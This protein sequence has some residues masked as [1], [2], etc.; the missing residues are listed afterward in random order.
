MSYQVI[1]PFIQF[2]D[3]SNGKPLSAGTVY[4]GRMDSDPKN[5]PANRINVYAVQDNGSEVLLSQPIDL[6]GAGQP[7]VSGSVKQIR[8]ELYAGEQSYAIQIFNRRGAQKGYCSRV[9]G[10]VDLQSLSSATSE[11]SIAGVAARDV[12]LGVKYISKLKD[13]AA[14]TRSGITINLE[15]IYDGWAS[16]SLGLPFGGGE[17][18]Y[19][20]TLSKSKH[21]GATVIAPEAII[22]WDGT[23]ANIAT[24]FN[25]TGSGVGCFVRASGYVDATT[26]FADPNGVNESAAC[27]SAYAKSM[28]N[29]IMRIPAGNYKVSTAIQNLTAKI[30]IEGAGSNCTFINSYLASGRVFAF[31]G[32]PST[33]AYTHYKGFAVISFT[34][35][36]TAFNPADAAY[37]LFEDITTENFAI[38]WELDSVLTS[39]FIKCIGRF[40]PAT[41]TGV[42]ASNSGSSNPNA[43]TFIGC[44]FSSLGGPGLYL[45][46][47]SRLS[48]I[49]GSLESCGTAGGITGQGALV[50]ENGGGQGAAA[51]YIQTYFEGNGGIAD[52]WVKQFGATPFS[53]DVAN[54]CF[55]RLPAPRYADNCIRLTQSAATGFVSL[56]LGNASTFQGFGG[57]VPAIARKYVFIDSASGNFRYHDDSTN[58]YES[59]LELPQINP[60]TLVYGALI[61]V[62]MRLYSRG[63]A[64]HV[65][66][67]NGS[68]FTFENPQNGKIGDVVTIFISNVYGA[69]G[70]ITFDTAYRTSGALTAPNINFGAFISF[71]LSSDG[72]WLEESRSTGFQTL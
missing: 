21:N 13:M 34:L 31:S 11:V 50:I 16:T 52:L 4:F 2:V 26:W 15:S 17:F 61:P 22:A 64:A 51:A 7:S 10:V 67:T 3:P 55:N 23:A 29:G 59:G 45:V 18:S 19:Q 49:G 63:D 46:N 40:G 57:Y 37:L 43:L 24:L 48:Y 54:S 6:N 8:V 30:S 65:T 41:A 47:P 68:N 62:D 42:L 12:A 20:P 35:A 70:A 72:F 38:H 25:W 44:T 39:V 27:L 1:N 14:L 33:N 60:T 32:L 69:P 66:I 28:T 58:F 36:G 9:S 56:R 71:K 53:I 5:Q